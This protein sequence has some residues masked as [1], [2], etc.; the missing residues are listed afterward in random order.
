MIWVSILLL[1]NFREFDLQK[2][3]DRILKA[4]D[5]YDIVKMRKLVETKRRVIK[6]IYCNEGRNNFKLPHKSK[7]ERNV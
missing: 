2:F 5:D 3:Q 1:K 4:F 7:I 6:E